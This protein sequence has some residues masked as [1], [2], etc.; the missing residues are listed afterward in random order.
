MPRKFTLALLASIVLGLIAGSFPLSFTNVAAATWEYWINLPTNTDNQNAEL[1]CGWHT[2]ACGSGGDQA[3]DWSTTNNANTN[4][5]FRG[6][7]L[8][9]VGTQTIG[10]WMTPTAVQGIYSNCYWNIVATVYNY[11]TGEI[12]MRMIYVHGTTPWADANLWYRNPTYINPGTKV[13]V[14]ATTSD[15]WGCGWTGTHTHAFPSM[16]LWAWLRTPASHTVMFLG[17]RTHSTTT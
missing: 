13:G 5:Y 14:M 12:Q 2:Y 3:L 11:F 9:P 15:P 7:G 4:I 10:G 17:H 8:A 6:A 1:R 16:E